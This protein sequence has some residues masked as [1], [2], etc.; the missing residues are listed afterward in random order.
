MPGFILG[1]IILLVDP[2][3]TRR[4]PLVVEETDRRIQEI[5]VIESKI[6]LEE[7]TD[8]ELVDLKDSLPKTDYV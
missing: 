8:S 2:A 4:I 1:E 6:S 5:E 3:F 7:L